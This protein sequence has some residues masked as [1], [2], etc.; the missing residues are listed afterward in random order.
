MSIPSKFEGLADDARS[1]AKRFDDPEASP[2]HVAFVV[3]S[4]FEDRFV[5]EFGEDAK[6]KIRS[7]LAAGEGRRAGG[8]AAM[9]ELLVA[10]AGSTGDTADALFGALRPLVME[11]ITAADA[12]AA[13]G[14]GPDPATTDVSGTG[15]AERPGERTAGERAGYERDAHSHDAHPSRTVLT[16]VPSPEENTQGPPGM[17]IPDGLARFV[18]VVEPAD[19]GYRDEV[20]REIVAGLIVNGPGLPMLVGRRGTGRTSVITALATFLASS[21]APEDLAGWPVLR[22]DAIALLRGER[23]GTLRRIQDQIPGDFV[24]VLDDVELMCSL[25]LPQPD[26]EMLALLRSIAGDSARPVVAVLDS[27]HQSALEMFDTSLAPQLHYVR[28]GELDNRSVREIVD[29]EAAALAA[30]HTV[31]IPDAV[32][33]VACSAVR[34][35]GPV[36][37]PGL[38]VSR[39]EIAAARAVVRHHPTVEMSDLDLD[40]AT[41]SP[42][43]IDVDDLRARLESKIV[44]QVAAVE[45][46]VD[47]LAL[48]KASLDLYPHRPDGVFLFLGPTGVGKTALARAISEELFGA[49]TLIRLDMSEYAQE[50]AIARLIGPQPGYVGYT[51]PQGWLTTRVREAGQCVVLLDEIEKAHQRVWNT[52]LQVFDAGRLTDSRGNVADFSNVVVIMTSNVGAETFTKSEVGFRTNSDATLQ[53][54]RVLEQLRETMSP[55][56]INRIDEVAV[57]RALS[58]EDISAVARIEVDRAAVRLRNRGYVIHVPDA[59]VDSLARTGYDKRYGARHVQRNI[60]R[61]LLQ[62]LVDCNPGAWTAS[63]VGDSSDKVIWTATA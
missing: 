1:E 8:E 44:G 45:R 6:S 12:V 46:L 38:A 4:R 19:V 58:E 47:R 10:A 40:T 27:R 9:A 41:G 31:E 35:D 7:A 36:G 17:K 22:V 30:I 62:S 13:Q 26:V 43:R 37:H 18:A 14:G 11:T 60:E 39:L 51:E 53:A 33:E 15:G 59:V 21:E 52:F 16:A 32:I 50:W 24:L 23:A 48:T 55:E 29:G 61:L 42:T 57:F 25:N 56:L 5:K 63:W 28:L 34:L 20:V 3:A 49:D 54:D 2:L